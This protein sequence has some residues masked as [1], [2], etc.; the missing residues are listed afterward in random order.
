MSG[1]FT[2]KLQV[3]FG[4]W[5]PAV[6]R[7]AQ[8]LAPITWECGDVLVVIPAGTISDGATVPRPLWWFLPPWGDEAT[9][10]AVL[11]DFICGRLDE[12][13]PVRGCDSRI[14]C[15]L[16]F[17]FAL[18]AQDVPE[19]RALAAFLGVRIYSTFIGRWIR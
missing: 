12:G 2:G 7:M 18:Q 11:H 13:N 8:T 3:E 10:P 1:R 17:L 4:D 19:W 14:E 15:D 16:Q 9:L 5:G 6:G